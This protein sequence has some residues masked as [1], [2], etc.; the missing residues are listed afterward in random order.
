MEHLPRGRRKPFEERRQEDKDRAVKRARR[1]VRWACRQIGATHLMT[2]TTRQDRNSPE[3]L[4][5]WWKRF[6]RLVRV[7]LGVD[8]PYVAVPEPHPKNP[9][10]WHLHV[11]VRGFI[12]IN[13]ARRCWWACC[14]GRGMGNIDLKYI[15]V[16]SG[17]GDGERARRV[18][19]Y[20]SKYM[21]K[22][23]MGTHRPDKKNY[24]R[25]VFDMPDVTRHWLRARPNA[26]D[27][28]ELL[29]EFCDRFGLRWEVLFRDRSG[30][31][32][33]PDGSGFWYSHYAG[34]GGIAEPPF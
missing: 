33:F 12:P 2:L 19:S 10:H 28:S 24:W 9:G 6:V 34:K 14:G 18:A 13:I 15:K 11:A 22:A 20:L 16:R 30:L 29:R 7:R 3:E 23:L 4:A 21:S 25:S 31:F 17:M 1:N 27:W 32:V 8:L 26:D 5:V